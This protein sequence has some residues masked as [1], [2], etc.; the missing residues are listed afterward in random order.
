M[1]PINIIRSRDV[2]EH[3][4]SS[5]IKLL[6]PTDSISNT[7]KTF[8][9]VQFLIERRIKTFSEE[10][11]GLLIKLKETRCLFNKRNSRE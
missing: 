5:I 10:I 11:F 1:L 8:K 2:N 7:T 3:K 9:T 4:Y 6:Y